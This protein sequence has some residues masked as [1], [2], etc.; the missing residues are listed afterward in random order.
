MEYIIGAGAILESGEDGSITAASLHAHV[1]AALAQRV[2]V[3]AI[4]FEST[5]FGNLKRLLILAQGWNAAQFRS[6]V[7]EPLRSKREC[8]LADVLST[9]ARGAGVTEVHLFAH[10]LP[11]EATCS[12]L[13]DAGIELV[14]HPLESID[15]A[16]LVS[17]QH[18][19]LWKAA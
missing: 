17:G 10:W 13:E 2:R 19:E 4:D 3:A 11:D 1:D 6:G 8:T 7:T 15:A 18:R 16:A 14:C 5:A 12:T 9:L